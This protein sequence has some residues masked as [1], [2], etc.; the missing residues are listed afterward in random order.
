[1]VYIVSKRLGFFELEIID[2]GTSLK[3]IIKDGSI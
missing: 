2:S 1:M 3:L